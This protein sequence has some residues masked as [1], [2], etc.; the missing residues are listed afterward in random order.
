MFARRSSNKKEN[1]E[2]GKT[3]RQGRRARGAP[4]EYEKNV[5]GK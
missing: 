4:S 5:P 3:K 2:G 1:P